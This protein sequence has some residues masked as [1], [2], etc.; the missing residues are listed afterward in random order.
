[1]PSQSQYMSLYCAKFPSCLRT[2]PLLV[3]VRFPYRDVIAA[4]RTGVGNG[5]KMSQRWPFCHASVC[6]EERSNHTDSDPADQDGARDAQASCGNGMNDIWQWNEGLCF[7]LWRPCLAARLACEYARSDDSVDQ[8]QY[9]RTH[10]PQRRVVYGMKL[11]RAW[12]MQAARGYCNCVLRCGVKL[13]QTSSLELGQAERVDRQST[14]WPRQ[15]QCVYMCHPSL[16]S[17]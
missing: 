15:H 9:F 2:G 14:R 11:A 13:S 17:A 1:M 12:G 5:R 10:G 6:C 16:P 4:C 3:L 8:R 7:D